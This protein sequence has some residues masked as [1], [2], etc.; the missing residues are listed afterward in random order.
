VALTRSQRNLAIGTDA[1]LLFGIVQ[2]EGPA[3][4]IPGAEIVT[5]REI[6][7]A[8]RKVP[9]AKVDPSSEA[10]REYRE[11]VET[12]FRDHAVLPAPFGTVFKSREALLAW[13]E[14]HYHALV[15]ALAFVH[16]RAMARVRFAAS[17]L[18]DEQMTETREVRIQDFETTVFDSFRFL[19]RS[20]VALVTFPPQGKGWTAR[21]LEASFL[22]DR[23]K[24]PAFEQAVGEEQQRLPEFSI[25]QSGPWPPYDFVRLQFGG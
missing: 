8:V 2:H 19:K 6:T 4:R 14:L 12:A 17:G 11:A 18:P 15:D 23:E 3:F 24:W 10:I 21:S 25:E 22:V 9:Y 7:A 16:D 5:L 1:L 20:A 13:L